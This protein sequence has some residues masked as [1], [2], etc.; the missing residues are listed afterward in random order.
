MSAMRAAFSQQ[1]FIATRRLGVVF[2]PT[3]APSLSL[4]NFILSRLTHRRVDMIFNPTYNAAHLQALQHPH[5]QRHKS[6]RR[7]CRQIR[8]AFWASSTR[9]PDSRNKS[10]SFQRYD[11]SNRC[12]CPFEHSVPGIYLTA[13]NYILPTRAADPAS[14][15]KEYHRTICI[16]EINSNSYL[17]ACPHLWSRKWRRRRQQTKFI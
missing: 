10:G 1:G 5:H 6:K 13:S 16:G 7:K 2:T 8:E 17:T 14:S 3:A 4:P 15:P 12:R 9:N 11:D